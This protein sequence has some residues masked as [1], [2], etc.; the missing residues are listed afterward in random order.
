MSS[1][2]TSPFWVA[3]TLSVSGEMWMETSTVGFTAMT[4]VLSSKRLS[5]AL[6]HVNQPPYEKTG[7]RLRSALHHVQKN[8]HETGLA[9]V[10]VLLSMVS[11][12]QVFPR[13][14]LWLLLKLLTS[15]FLGS[16]STEAGIVVD[17]LVW[18]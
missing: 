12:K 4:A 11:S 17:V 3:P 10:A 18:M 8:T 9:E 5:L 14:L 13:C 6:T 7:T 2:T 1:L 15:M 16:N